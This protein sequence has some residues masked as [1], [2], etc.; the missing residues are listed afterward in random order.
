MTMFEDS[1]LPQTDPHLVLPALTAHP[2]PCRPS[3]YSARMESSRNARRWCTLCPC[4]RSTSSTPAPRASWLSSQVSPA[5]DMASSLR[6]LCS[7]TSSLSAPISCLLFFSVSLV[8]P[9]LILPSKPL[10]RAAWQGQD[11]VLCPSSLVLFQTLWFFCC[12][13]TLDFLSFVHPWHPSFLLP[14][15]QPWTC[16]LSDFR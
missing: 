15:F 6:H 4:T 11:P 12:F 7:L 5:L 10:C 14:T 13:T 2:L 3:L 1:C 16:P 9:S 8:R